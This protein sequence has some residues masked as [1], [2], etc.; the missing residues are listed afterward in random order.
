[1]ASARAPG[2]SKN[3]ETGPEVRKG[4]EEHC[5]PDSYHVS[6]DAGLTNKTQSNEAIRMHKGHAGR[7]KCD[8]GDYVCSAAPVSA[9]ESTWTRPESTQVGVMSEGGC[10]IGMGMHGKRSTWRGLAILIGVVLLGGWRQE[11]LGQEQKLTLPEGWVIVERMPELIGGQKSLQ[12]LIQ[13]P[14]SAYANGIEGEVIVTVV[15]NEEGLVEDPVVKRGI[16]GGCDEEALRVVRQA[17]F[18][19]GISQGNPVK[20]RMSIPVTFELRK[21]RRRF[22]FWR[23]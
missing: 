16:G 18:T 15:V 19:P 1:M 8:S 11:V 22:R 3:D 21:A 20:I 4:E 12:K 9:C 14:D 2:A 13:Y 23:R 5:I 10:T 17:R 6:P 7:K